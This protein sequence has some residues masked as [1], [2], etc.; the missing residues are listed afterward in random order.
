MFV[1]DGKLMHFSYKRYIE[2]SLRKA[3][4]FSG[5]PIKIV[6]RSKDEDKQ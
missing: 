3:F 1:N 5:T 2:N 4:D 6:V